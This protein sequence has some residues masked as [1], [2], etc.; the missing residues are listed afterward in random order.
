MARDAREARESLPVEAEGYVIY[1]EVRER[2]RIAKAQAGALRNLRVLYAPE[3]DC[4]A[5]L[6]AGR[7]H[8][9]GCERGDFMEQL[10]WLRAATREPK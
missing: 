10:R 7:R 1:S 4:D 6:W 2:L 9:A 3:C 5:G 8:K